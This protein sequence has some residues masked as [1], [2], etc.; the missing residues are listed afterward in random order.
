M[1]LVP[2]MVLGVGTTFLLLAWLLSLPARGL[3]RFGAMGTKT[4]ELGRK[5]QGGLP[6]VSPLSL[7]T[8][9]K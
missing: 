8:L 1:W 4:L 5:E 9:G 2:R 7:R 3:M 6:L